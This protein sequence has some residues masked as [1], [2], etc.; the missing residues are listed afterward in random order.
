MASV[1]QRPSLSL[2]W[3]YGCDVEKGTKER[4]PES[5]HAGWETRETGVRVWVRTPSGQSGVPLQKVGTWHAG[6]G[7]QGLVAALC[8][9]VLRAVILAIFVMWRLCFGDAV[10]CVRHERLGHA[11]W[12][13]RAGTF[14]RARCCRKPP[15]DS[16]LTAPCPALWDL[17]S[18]A[19][20]APPS[21]LP[22]KKPTTQVAAVPRGQVHLPPRPAPSALLPARHPPSF[23][24]TFICWRGRKQ[25]ATCM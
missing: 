6:R 15:Q 25:L 8:C 13:A 2:K 7:W 10:L 20:G 14:D 18:S 12:T 24:A 9:V 3:S 21:H 16:V 5:D 1:K 22:T 4:H 19:P 23:P 11:R 17:A